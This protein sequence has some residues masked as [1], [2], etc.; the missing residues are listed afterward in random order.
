MGRKDLARKEHNSQLWKTAK[1]YAR[2]GIASFEEMLLR[3]GD[4]VP[5]P[6]PQ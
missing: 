6:F 5:I 3:G 2:E 1:A 4:G